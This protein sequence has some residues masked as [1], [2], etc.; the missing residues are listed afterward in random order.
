MISAIAHSFV[1]AEVSVAPAIMSCTQ[2]L[3]NISDDDLPRKG[4]YS[5]RNLLLG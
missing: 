1:T 3:L 2:N 4:S 5:E